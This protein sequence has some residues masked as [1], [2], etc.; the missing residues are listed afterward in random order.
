MKNRYIFRARIS[1]RQ[2][3]RT[4]RTDEQRV[5]RCRI[6]LRCTPPAATASVSASPP[7]KR[8]N[9]VCQADFQRQEVV[10]QRRVF[11]RVG[12]HGVVGGNETQGGVGGA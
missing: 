3:R 8:R 4:G 12:D 1:E 11:D 2:F 6:L 10:E 9:G 5:F 7:Q